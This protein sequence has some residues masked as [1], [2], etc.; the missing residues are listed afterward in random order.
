MLSRWWQDLRH[1]SL[2]L[3][4]W[5]AS[6]VV[7]VL[8][9]ASAYNAQ[10]FIAE[11][12]RQN[13]EDF[14]LQQLIV[15]RVRNVRDELW[16]AET[17]LNNTLIKPRIDETTAVPRYLNRAAE[18]VAWLQQLSIAPDAELEQLFAELAESVAQLQQRIAR[19]LQQRQD[20]EWVYPMLPFIDQ[21]LRQNHEAFV[22]HA[23]L[24]IDEVAGS[25]PSRENLELLRKLERIKSLWTSKV[26]DFRALVI[27]FAGLNERRYLRQ[28]QNI[29]ILHRQITRLLDALARM[30]AEG[31]LGLQTEAS[32]EEMQRLS[33]EWQKYY[34]QFHGLR[35]TNIWRNDLHY[36][37]TQI[38]P[39]Q[40]RI[41]RIFH[42]VES[43]LAD[44]S[45]RNVARMQAAHER[46]ATAVWI[47][48]LVAV[49]FIL[50]VYI[51]VD[52]AILRPLQRIAALIAGEGGKLESL[53]LAP[54][55]SHEIRVLVDAYN[56][57][58][59]EIHQHQTAL[60][61]QAM[62][63]ALTGL[64]NRALLHDRLEQAMHLANRQHTEMVFV[65]MDLDRFKEIN[66]T[67]GHPVGDQVLQQISQRLAA[68]L[69]ESDTVA[70][71]GGD[72][73]AI[74][75]NDLR[76]R[77][78]AAFLDKIVHVVS[79][80]ITVGGQDLYV[81]ASLGVALY[82]RHGQ[83]AA[84]LI[85]RADI[86]M[87]RAKRNKRNYVI[88]DPSFEKDG[89]DNLS[90]LGD[91]RAELD[92]PSGALRLHYQPQVRL[93]D[94]G[95]VSVE[96]LLRWEHPRQGFVS[97]ESVIRLAEQSGLMNALTRRI[98]A[99]AIA[100][101][102][103]WQAVHPSLG[104]SV[105][106]SAWDLQDAEL[107]GHIRDL[108]TQHNLSGER[109]NLE[110]TESAVMSDPVRAREVMH[111]LNRLGASLAIDDYGTGFSSL[112]YLK[113]LPVA[114]LKIDRSFVIDM[115]EDEND[116][117]IVRSTV[118]LAH[119]LSLEVVAEGVE[120]AGVL[121]LLRTLGCDAA[122][123]YHLARPMPIDHLLDWLAE[124][125]R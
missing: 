23:D 68:N 71:L 32:L 43:S 41:N 59:R 21:H 116:A 66:D 81:G 42:Q 24:A 96:A 77:E 10:R 117:I 120:N 103:A 107:P 31:K 78:A 73:F 39:V 85:R 13:A 109:L 93:A 25:P 84:T 33:Q 60:E 115:L 98:L 7:V 16:Q 112:A 47:F 46:V 61:H 1:S 9:V 45:G 6:S 26:L 52:H 111:Q 92:R 122:Q 55:G 106:L 14:R 19:L 44:W 91:L 94:L 105:N 80:V 28:E 62:H 75:A 113:L 11:V 69:R 3:R 118:E 8:L 110:I 53:S 97:P 40:A 50:F 70:R 34:R 123:G 101:C 102:A 125:S 29:E 119:N 57:M 86:A 36:V 49:S 104:V 58:R 83:D 100:D 54:T 30:G 88:Y 17:V 48:L 20:V 76:P 64:P 87:Y 38:R 89:L 56:Q 79:Q 2:R 65:L 12:A 108:L 5:L 37:Q 22:T 121:E 27:R 74:V 124:H 18:D 67:L 35:E 51:M 114:S 95:P 72:E 15:H 63:D 4:Y 99:Q 82:P 90:L